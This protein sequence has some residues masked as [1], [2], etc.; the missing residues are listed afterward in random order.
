MKRLGI[1]LA[2]VSA[3]LVIGGL[4][5]MSYSAY[6]SYAT[7]KSP[8]PA[9]S[10]YDVGPPDAQEML[11]LVNAERAKANV[12]ALTYSKP[13]ETVAQ[14]KTDDFHL[15]DYYS[16]E[17]KGQADGYW[18]TPEMK[19]IAQPLCN[20]Y[21]EN[22]TSAATSRETVTRWMNSTAHREAILDPT[23]ITTGFGI[24]EGKGDWYYVSEHF[25][26]AK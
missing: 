16:H 19:A 20:S 10:K 23:Y 9:P 11:E 22:L 5:F 12:P 17:I 14:M 4:S 21:A 18:L 24:S 3:I 15:R 26:V 2:I 13:I 8:T 1:A 6:L 25:C 7:A